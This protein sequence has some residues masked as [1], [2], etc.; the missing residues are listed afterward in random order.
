M[1]RPT[2]FTLI[3]LNALLVFVLTGEWFAESETVGTVQNTLKT[4]DAQDEELP[5]LD[6]E[7]KSEDE[8]SDLVERPLFIKGR[9]PVT[10]PIPESTPVAAVK[11]V[12]AFVWDLTGVFT[13]PKGVTAF[14]SRINAKVEKDNYRKLKLGEDI[15]GWKLSEIQPDKVTLT[16]TGETKTLPLR[17]AK[18]KNALPVSRVPASMAKDIRREPPLRMPP[19]NASEQLRGLP[20]PE[21]VKPPTPTESIQE[22]TVVVQPSADETD[23]VQQ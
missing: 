15:D 8:Y 9:K 17:K 21:S 23:N 6:L 5:S 19:P 7:A 12:E 3:A 11:K 2:L 14:F 13:T 18:P 4:I 20:P 10:E 22:N 16:Q 1:N